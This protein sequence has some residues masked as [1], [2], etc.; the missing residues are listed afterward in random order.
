MLAPV[1]CCQINCSKLV[2]PSK[3]VKNLEF[4]LET[5]LLYPITTEA[6]QLRHTNICTI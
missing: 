3:C 6:S 4:E 5:H 1:S 2:S